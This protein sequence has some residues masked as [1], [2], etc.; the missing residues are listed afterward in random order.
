MKN[1]L[2]ICLVTIAIQVIAVVLGFILTFVLECGSKPLLVLII[3]GY[4]ISLVTDIYLAVKISTIWY[5]KLIY[6]FLM[7]TNYTP[8]GLL[9]FAMYCFARF[10]EMLP[11]NLG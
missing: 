2:K 6:I 10:F 1:Y 8:I 4:V 9:W 7:P 3:I 5:K 11:N